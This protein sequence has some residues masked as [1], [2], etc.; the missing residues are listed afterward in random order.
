MPKDL[1][2]LNSPETELFSKGKTLFALDVA[3]RNITKQDEV[4]VV[5]G[6]FDAIALHTKGINNVVAVLG[7]ALTKQ[8]INQLSRYTKSKQIILNFDADKAGLQATKRAIKEVE[9]LVYYRTNQT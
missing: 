8:H 5:E 1:N 6:Y 2:I 9:N 4:I 7:T 3:Q